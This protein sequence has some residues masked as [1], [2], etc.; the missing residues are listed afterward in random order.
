MKASWKYLVVPLAVGALIF[1]GCGSDDSSDDSGSSDTTTTQSQPADNGA[2]G[3]QVPAG[4]RSVGC[5]RL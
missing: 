3:G 1:A 2:M 5:P 4:C